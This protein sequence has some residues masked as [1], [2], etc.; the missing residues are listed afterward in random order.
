[1]LFKNC[2]AC[3]DLCTGIILKRK[4][5]KNEKKGR[6]KILGRGSGSVTLHESNLKIPNSNGFSISLNLFSFF[7]F[8]LSLCSVQDTTSESFSDVAMAIFQTTFQL[9][10]KNNNNNKKIVVLLFSPR[11]CF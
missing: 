1:M 11:N 10:L 4:R 9:V 3:L 8:N 7:S 2:S 5:G 6:S